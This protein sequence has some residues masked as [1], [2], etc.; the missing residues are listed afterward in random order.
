MSDSKDDQFLVRAILSG[1]ISAFSTLYNKYEG[2]IY[3]LMLKMC[4]N[5]NTAEDLAH[6][7]FVKMYENLDRYDSHYKFFSWFYRLSMNIAINAGKRKREVPDNDN[8]TEPVDDSNPVIVVEKN[9]LKKNMDRW[10]AMLDIKYRSVVVL[11]YTQQ[12]SYSEMADILNIPEKK[13]KSRLY[14]AREILRTYIQKSGFYE[15]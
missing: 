12:L 7:A 6:D 15:E 10:I 4:G 1:D 9:E 14:S 5:P 11:K 8:Y 13:V 3:R 2:C